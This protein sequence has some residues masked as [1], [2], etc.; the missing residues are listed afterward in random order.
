MIMNAFACP[1]EPQP[2]EIVAE[3]YRQL[4]ELRQHGQEPTQVCL[5]VTF[6]RRLRIY[7]ALI[8]STSQKELDYLDQH[9]IFGLDYFVHESESVLVK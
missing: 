6:I 3:I 9:S 7:H 4:L 5:P 8:G 1:S 2:E